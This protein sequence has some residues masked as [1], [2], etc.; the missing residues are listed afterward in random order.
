MPSRQT[1][2]PLGKTDDRGA[3]CCSHATVPQR[4]GASVLFPA[5]SSMSTI[6]GRLAAL[7]AVTAV[8]LVLSACGSKTGESKSDGA[9]IDVSGDTV[10]VG[11]LN[12]LSGTMAI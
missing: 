2:V 4:R 12:S 5:R 9:T 6:R 3:G 1:A 10:K 7:C 8:A 11:L